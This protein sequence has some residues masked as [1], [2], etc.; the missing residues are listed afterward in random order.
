MRLFYVDIP[1]S[2]ALNDHVGPSVSHFRSTQGNLDFTP[3]SLPSSP[4][5]KAQPRSNAASSPRPS[6][7]SDYGPATESSAKDYVDHQ[8]LL[9]IPDVSPQSKISRSCTKD[10]MRRWRRGMTMR[11][12][13]SNIY[14]SRSRGAKGRRRRRGPLMVSLCFCLLLDCV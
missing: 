12:T 6:T 3:Q 5:T 10:S 14:Y 8:S 7:L 11:R 4:H 2:S 9:I 1:R 13:D